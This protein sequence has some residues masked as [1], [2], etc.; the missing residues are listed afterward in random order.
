VRR[1]IFINSSGWLALYN[2]NDPNHEAARALWES[3]P[4]QDVRF[5]TTDYVL[6]QVYTALKVF[7]SLHAAQAVHQVIS[8]SHLVRLFLVDSVIFDRAWRIFVDDEQPH[9]TFTDCI[10][11]AVIQYTGAAEVFT[12]DPSFS[13][14]GMKVIPDAPH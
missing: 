9:W 14:P 1:L 8:R 12:F 4:G 13:A 5:V 6:D 3:L 7:G 11:Y 2:H 10:N